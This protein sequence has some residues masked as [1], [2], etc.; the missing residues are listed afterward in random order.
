MAAPQ[1]GG[2]ASQKGWSH[3]EGAEPQG[4]AVPHGGQATERAVPQ[5]GWSHG[6]IETGKES[7]ERVADPQSRMRTVSVPVKQ[8]GGSDQRHSM[9]HDRN[10]H[11]EPSKRPSLGP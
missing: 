4:G 3:A 7:Q 11:L 5:R 9:S 6:A 1:R 10:V 8:V 2:G